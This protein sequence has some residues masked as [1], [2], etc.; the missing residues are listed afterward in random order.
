MRCPGAHEGFRNRRVSDQGAGAGFVPFEGGACGR[1]MANWSCSK[2]VCARHKNL[3]MRQFHEA[4]PSS[5]ERHV[6]CVCVCVYV[7]CVFELDV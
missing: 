6:S 1:W 3:D 7:V 5:S 4:T 2:Q